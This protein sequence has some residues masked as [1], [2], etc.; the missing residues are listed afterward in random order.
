MT[1]SDPET[2]IVI[3]GVEMQIKATDSIDYINSV[4]DD[5]LVIATSEVAL[6]SGSIDG[7]YTNEELTNSVG[8]ALGGSTVD[9]PDTAMDAI[10]AGVGGLG[11][12]QQ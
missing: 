6:T 8:L 7:G 9:I 4:N 11:L 5:I 10:L 1:R 3:D 12:L 2:D